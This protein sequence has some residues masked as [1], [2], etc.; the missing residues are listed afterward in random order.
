VS[1]F[2]AEMPRPEPDRDDREFW[3]ACAER[4]LCF[5]ACASCGTLRHPPRPICHVCQATGTKWLEAPASAVLYTYCVA[6]HANH[7][8]VATR[9]PYIVGLVEFPALPGVRLVTNITDMSPA[10]VRI[11][12][13]VRLWWDD[14]G[15]GMYVPR[16]RGTPGT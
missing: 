4:R 1:Y 10:D 9:V 6:H 12:M 14:I 2:P 3:A 5:Q 13:E 8:A 7:P 11:G 15:E 16:F